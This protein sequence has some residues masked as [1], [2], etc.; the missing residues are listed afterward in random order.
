MRT[1][2]LVNKNGVAYMFDLKYDLE[3]GDYTIYDADGAYLWND[4]LNVD[5]DIESDITNAAI[6]FCEEYVS[7]NVE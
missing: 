4:V 6:D 5:T 2:I 7:L 3:T 1:K